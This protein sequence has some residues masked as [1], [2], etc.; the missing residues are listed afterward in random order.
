MIKITGLILG[1][2]EFNSKRPT[3]TNQLQIRKTTILQKSYQHI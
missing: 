2:F 1:M 3:D